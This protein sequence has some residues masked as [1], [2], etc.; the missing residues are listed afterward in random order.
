MGAREQ[1]GWSVGAL[2]LPIFG[3]FG[4]HPMMTDRD[5]HR[6]QYHFRSLK[7]NEKRLLKRPRD[8]KGKTHLDH[9]RDSD[10]VFGL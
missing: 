3:G 5:I 9:F 10:F 7:E 4:V 8:P 6:V 2:R 1:S